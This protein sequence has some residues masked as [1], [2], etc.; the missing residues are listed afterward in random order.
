MDEVLPATPDYEV[1]ETPARR[2]SRLRQMGRRLLVL[3]AALLALV[4]IGVAVFNSPIGHRYVVDQIARVAPASGLRFT[5]G[6]IDGSLYG[7]A[8][9]HDVTVSDPK[10]AFMTV[11]LVELDWRPFNWLRSGLDVRE[12]VLHRGRLMRVPELLPGDPDAPILPNFDIRVD[13]FQI[14]DL[15]VAEGIAGPQAHRLNLAGKA[16]VR[17]GQ[18]VARLDGAVGD[19]DRVHL[20]LDARPDDDKFD[21]DLDYDA[22]RD[23]VIAA[24]VGGDAAYRAIVRGNGSWREWRGLAYVARDGERFAAFRLANRGGRYTA[25]GQLRP[26]PALSGFLGDLAGETVSLHTTFTLKDSVANGVFITRMGGADARGTGAVDLTN[27]RF[28]A[29]RVE[30]LLRKPDLFGNAARL[31]NARALAT[32]DGPFRELRLRHMVRVGRVTVGTTMLDDVYQDGLARY[33]GARWLIP[34]EA[35]VGRVTTGN[36]ML[37]PRLV[38]GRIAGTLAYTGRRLDSDQ[39]TLSFPTANARLSLRGDLDAGAFGLAGPVNV[40]NLQ[41]EN[42]GT[43]EGRGDIVL[44]YGRGGYDLRAQVNGRMPRVTNATLANLAGGNIRFSGGVGMGSAGPL[45]FQNF[46]LAATKLQLTLDGRVTDRGTTLAGRGRH[47]DYGPFTV[48]GEVTQSGPRAV[49]VFANP[50]PAADLRNVRVAIAPTAGGFRIDTRGGSMLGPFDGQLDLFAPA[51]A[52]VRVNIRQMTISSTAVTGNLVLLGNAV[53][54]NLAL[55][56]GGVDGTI[57]LAPRGR[58]Q[59]FD[60]KLLARDASF[61]GETPLTV[62]F[63]DVD[64]SGIWAGGNYSVQGTARAEGLSYGTLFLGRMV[65]RANVV[66]GEGTFDAQMRGSRGSRFNLQVTGNASP[67]RI[68]V[69]ARG[70]IA[71]RPIT[72]PR[73]A[74]LTRL[75]NGGWALAPTQVNLGRGAMIAEGRIGAGAPQ[76]RLHLSQMPLSLADL[77]GL[78][79]GLGGTASG[80]VDMTSGARGVPVGEARVQID[81]L[82][83]S[84]LVLT[85]APIDVALVARL[86]ERTLET[87][88]IIDENGQRRGRLQ[89]RITGLPATGGLA[90]RLQRGSLFAQFR[91]G[92]PA[93]G[94][95]RLAAIDAFDVT[96]PVNV[97]ADITGTLADPA[98]RGSLASD[99]LRVQSSLSGTDL[100]NAAIR[101]NFSGSRLRIT[102]FT[103]T[104]PNGGTVLGS[105]TVNLSNIGGG[106]GPGLDL[107]VSARN[108]R[109]LDN[110]G[111]V[112]AITGPLRIVSDGVGGTIAGRVAI[113]RASWR[114]GTAAQDL[115]LPNIRTREIN[116]AIDRR[117][118]AAPAAPWRYLIN[119]RGDDR[120]EVDGMGLDSEWGANIIL[121]GTTDDPRIGGTAQ[122]VRG[123]YTF[124]GAQFELTRGR[125]AFDV[126]QPIN[127]RVDI[128]AE[129]EADGLD[130]T[131]RVQ[132]SAMSPDISFTSVPGLPEEEILARLLFGGSITNLSATDALQLGAALASLRGGEGGGLDPIN[133]LRTAIGL[134]RLRIVSADPAL[135]RGTAIALGKTLGRRF[136]AEIVTDGRGYSATNVEFR[137]T[138]WLSLLGSLSTIGRESI[139]AEIS[140]DY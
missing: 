11:P 134:D 98:V 57:A 41:L 1:S 108:A 63:A 133:R 107:R 54:G 72:M 5:V 86:T 68:A 36:A 35:R 80:I 51:N 114:L 30:T 3:V 101:G 23:G 17:D 130:V 97:A 62:A 105:G 42:L 19:K 88:A 119:A 32:L 16:N 69:A 43:V 70:S 102:R 18:V 52:P 79:L 99:N 81:N 138:S 12:L 103:G 136:Y 44:R 28:T 87:R 74:V 93:E 125:I 10:G 120:I 126:G 26:A 40:R 84:G 4:A 45:R 65:A 38:N 122:V 39:L 77:A 132:G 83:R 109:L 47:V 13:R 139:S 49:L 100:R 31:D 124:A 96:G 9:L 82:V 129:S 24:L 15:T 67:Q 8:R 85:S 135:G 14:I 37:D 60:V 20:A 104:A 123:E 94:L 6:R 95:W 110:A 112:A 66:N 115:R 131:V 92:G 113:D 34:L 106:R 71:G 140:R 73:R 137:V 89:G 117:V 118:A 75:R 29:L 46:R 48:E 50:L 2:R 91:Y 56:G 127:P 116:Q 59:G 128:V 33:N 64:A 61:G 90:Q 53:R 27:N 111:L 21:I 25:L 76:M 58:G 121:R 78:E 55:S 22:P 7:R